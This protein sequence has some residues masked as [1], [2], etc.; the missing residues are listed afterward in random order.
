MPVILREMTPEELQRFLADALTDA[1]LRPFVLAGNTLEHAREMTERSFAEY[2]PGGTPAPGHVVFAV[3]ESGEGG[4]RGVR[5]GGGERAERVERAERDERVERAPSGE[6]GT[7]GTP[8]GFVW[9]GPNPLAAAGAW[10]VWDVEIDEAERGRGLGRAAMQLTEDYVRG[11]GGDTLGL[12][13]MGYNT[14]AK[15][16]YESLGF[17]TASTRMRKQL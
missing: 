14:A 17:E 9:V 5:A 3:E 13:V 12:N 8:V 11:Q 10:W 15:R 1:R 16:L 4:E 2:F 7:S 6:S